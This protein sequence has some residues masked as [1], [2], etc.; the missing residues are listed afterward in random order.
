MKIMPVLMTR[1]RYFKSYLPKNYQRIIKDL[2]SHAVFVHIQ[3]TDGLFGIHRGNDSS[4]LLQSTR[5]LSHV[6]T[7]N[8]YIYDRTYCPCVSREKAEFA[9]VKSQC[10]PQVY[11][12]SLV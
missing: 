8:E 11:R 1:Q 5:P 7:A 3:N 9:D 6:G 2:P 12:F 4:C 10:S